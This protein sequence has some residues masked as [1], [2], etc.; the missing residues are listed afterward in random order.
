MKKKSIKL[1]VTLALEAM[2]IAFD[3]NHHSPKPWL[4]VEDREKSINLLK[5]SIQLDANEAWPFIK[6]AELID[7]PLEKMSLYIRSLDFEDNIYA[8]R[9]IYKQIIKDHPE[10][11][12]NYKINNE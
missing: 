12:N 3:E 5:K 2:N 9:Y 1:W 10:L 6:L 8:Y 11:I 4:S 7:N